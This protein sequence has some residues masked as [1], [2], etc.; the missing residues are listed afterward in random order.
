MNSYKNKAEVKITLAGNTKTIVSNEVEALLLID[1]TV[2]KSQLLSIVALG[3]EQEYTIVITNTNLSI[4]SNIVFKDAIPSG[5][6][7]VSGS[8]KVNG[9]SVTPTV[10]SNEI[11]YNLPSLAIGATTITFKVNVDS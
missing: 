8:F 9:S 11:T 1:P 2:V 3:S 7:Y 10:S 4:L 5:M 6:S